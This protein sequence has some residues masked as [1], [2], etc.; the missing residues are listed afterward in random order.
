MEDK[1]VFEVVY[2]DYLPKGVS[3]PEANKQEAL[4]LTRENLAQIIAPAYLDMTE[5]ELIDYIQAG[6]KEDTPDLPVH[7][8]SSQPRLAY[9]EGLDKDD[10]LNQDFPE[11][12]EDK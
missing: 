6:E 4:P 2:K 3:F 10:E 9:A 12:T 11:P 7:Q 5:D 8:M 1:K